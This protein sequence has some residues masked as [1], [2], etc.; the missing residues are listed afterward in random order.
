M[1][2]LALSRLEKVKL[3]IAETTSPPV[4]LR[5]KKLKRENLVAPTLTS[6]TFL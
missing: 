4:R 6:Q 3:Q 1:L 5:W 2:Q